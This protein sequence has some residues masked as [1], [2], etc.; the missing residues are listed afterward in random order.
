MIVAANLKWPWL[1]ETAARLRS[2][3]ARR[4]MTKFGLVGATGVGVNLAVFTL[5]THVFQLHYLLAGP[6]GIETALISNYL[7]NNNWTFSDRSSGFASWAG[8]GR[9]HVVSIG[10]TLINMAVLHVLAGSF[11]VPPLLA[12]LVG[13]GVATSWNFL[14][15]VNWTWRPRTVLVAAPAPVRN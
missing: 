9:Y 3:S 14:L 11:G 13:I 8:L 6:I 5:L 15:S 2:R 7:L 1:A 12:N 4:R 10:A